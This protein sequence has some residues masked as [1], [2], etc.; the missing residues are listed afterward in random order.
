MLL[1]SDAYSSQEEL[2]LLQ[3]IGFAALLSV[4]AR[5][6]DGAQV[7]SGQAMVLAARMQRPGARDL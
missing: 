4:L 2:N 5:F 7:A 3:K 1:V 6:G